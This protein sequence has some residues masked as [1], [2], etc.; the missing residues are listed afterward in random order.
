MTCAMQVRQLCHTGS[1]QFLPHI[2][3][4]EFGRIIRSSSTAMRSR[5]D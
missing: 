5:S 3:V 4:V 1:H 2:I